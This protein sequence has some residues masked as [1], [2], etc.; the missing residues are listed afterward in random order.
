MRWQI[1][2]VASLA[3]LVAVGCDEQPMEPVA[4]SD[5]AQLTF[6][7]ANA[8]QQYVW[9]DQDLSLDLCGVDYVRFLGTVRGHYREAA[10]D[11]QIHT[12][13]SENWNMT[14]VGYE[15][16]LEWSLNAVIGDHDIRLGPSGNRVFTNRTVW[17]IIGKGDAP[18]FR[19]LIIA[20]RTFNANGELVASQTLREP[21]CD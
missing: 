2:L 21:L 6:N 19:W 11:D 12:F 10:V 16:G 20:H 1:P 3:L 5:L 13:F 9:T 4:N 17:T 14:G 8:A 15:T 18:S 7:A